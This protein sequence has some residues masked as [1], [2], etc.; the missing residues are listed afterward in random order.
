M[1]IAFMPRSYSRTVYRKLAAALVSV[2]LL[3]GCGGGSKQRSTPPP[4]RAEFAA[5]ADTVCRE[6]KSHRAR[7]A[8]LRKLR[9]PADERDLYDHL[10]SAERL[11]VEAA[12]VIEHRRKQTDIDP[13]VQLAVAEGKIAGYADRLGARMCRGAPDGTI[14]S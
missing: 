1:T 6:A 3:A 10:L 4:T 11:A 13:L 14:S 9:P 2:L 5:A 12:D 7:I 8:G